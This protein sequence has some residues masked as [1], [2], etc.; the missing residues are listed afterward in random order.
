MV[1]YTKESGETDIKLT[2][3][4]RVAVWGVR[5]LSWQRGLEGFM[6]ILGISWAVGLLVS[7]D[8][9]QTSCALPQSKFIPPSSIAVIML[10]SCTVGF[11]GMLHRSSYL[12][13]QTSVIA[14]MA[15]GMRVVLAFE[16]TVRPWHVI[17]MYTCFSLAELSIYVRIL[18]GLDRRENQITKRA[19]RRE[20]DSAGGD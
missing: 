20:S 10:I 18:T 3:I 1:V 8:Y 17:A 15:W 4:E 5:F 12:R 14:F 19:K 6:C 16:A 7:G 9:I 2:L 13:M 11:L